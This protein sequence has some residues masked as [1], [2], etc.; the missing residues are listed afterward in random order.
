M[1]NQG[2]WTVT[3]AALKP[4]LRTCL[5]AE[6]SLLTCP[7]SEPSQWPAQRQSIACGFTW[8]GSL[9]P[10]LRDSRA[11]SASRP[12]CRIQLKYPCR[13]LIGRVWEMALPTVKRSQWRT[14][15]Q[16]PVCGPVWSQSTAWG[17]A[18]HTTRREHGIQPTTPPSNL[19]H[20][21]GITQLEIPQ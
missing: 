10:T 3:L 15:S 9:I 1:H 5:F 7:G 8:P 20:G 6:H 18:N 17:L 4:S 11:Q 14:W 2:G 13:L 12:H 19:E 21:S 16:S